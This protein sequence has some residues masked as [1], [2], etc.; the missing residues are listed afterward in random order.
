MT[1]FSSLYF[2]HFQQPQKIESDG[3]DDEE[4]CDQ[5]SPKKISKTQKRNLSKSITQLQSLKQRSKNA[6]AKGKKISKFQKKSAKT[7]RAK[8][9]HPRKNVQN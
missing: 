7:K 6:T 2:L 3:D 8:F 9:F 5:T 4:N 1:R